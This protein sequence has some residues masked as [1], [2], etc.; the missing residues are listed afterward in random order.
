MS[1]GKIIQ[2]NG[3]NIM[4]ITHETCVLDDEGNPITETIGDVSLLN[5]E[6][7]NLVGAVNE[8]FGD[9]IKEQVVDALVDNNVVVNTNDNWSTLINGIYSIKDNVPDDTE[10]LAENLVITNNIPEV[11]EDKTLYVISNSENNDN[12]NIINTNDS[13]NYNEG[14]IIIKDFYMGYVFSLVTRCIEEIKTA[15]Y[16]LQF[17]NGGFV[18]LDIYYNLNNSLEK[19]A[20]QHFVFTNDSTMTSKVSYIAPGAGSCNYTILPYISMPYYR[21]GSN[22][23]YY[24]ASMLIDLGD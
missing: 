24:G 1:D 2:E 17:L 6:S 4:P 8:V 20:T 7:R 22:S 11:C 12:I 16:S 23:T 3:E 10:Y 21:G 18:P 15:T 5:T 13:F 9:I 14:D 19:I